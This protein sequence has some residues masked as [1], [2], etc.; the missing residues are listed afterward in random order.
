MNFALIHVYFYYMKTTKKQKM[1]KLQSF[2][3]A[4]FMSFILKIIAL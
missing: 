1:L 3:I 2:L 4:L